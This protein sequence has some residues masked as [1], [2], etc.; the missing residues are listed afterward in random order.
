MYDC[1]GQVHLICLV[2]DGAGSAARSGDGAELACQTV[3][4]MIRSDLLNSGGE[5]IERTRAFAYV[6]AARQ[7]LES[8]ATS[9]GLNLRDFACTLLGAVIHQNG[10]LFFQ[11]GDGGIVASSRDRYGIV[12]WPEDGGYANATYFLTE[13][14]SESHLSSVSVS[15]QIDEIA[16]FSDGLQRL[17]LSFDSKTPHVSF[18]DRMLGPLRQKAPDACDLLEGPLIKV[19]QSDDVNARTDD[20]KTLVLAS[21]R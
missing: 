19:L 15:S 8:K 14:G 4:N 1:H 9:E 20:D 3:A 16:L 5:R 7:A 17:V 11:I 2:S 13:L 18:F 21:R 6:D 10:A 12:F